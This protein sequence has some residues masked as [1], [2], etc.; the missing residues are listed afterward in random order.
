MSTFD[1][2]QLLNDIKSEITSVV[3]KHLL[4]HFEQMKCNNENIKLIETVLKQMPEF[5]RL[6]RENEDL[7][8]ELLNKKPVET[9]VA[10]VIVN[11]LPVVEPSIKLEL[12]ERNI[13]TESVSESELYKVVSLS[14][15]LVNLQ[16]G[17]AEEDEPVIEEEAEEVASEVAEEEEEAEEAE[18]A[19]EAAEEEASEAAEEEEEEEAEEAE[20]EEEE[21]ASEAAEEEEEE[22]ASEAAEEEASEAAEE[23]EEEEEAEEDGVEGAEPLEEP[24]EEEEVSVVKIKGHGT[25]YTN[26]A[27]NGDIYKMEA[28][29]EVGDQVGKFVNSFPI[30]F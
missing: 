4:P 26:N 21:E 23:E 3:E 27:V 8:R 6:E 25:F 14:E 12:T 16:V 28:D 17:N 29:E 22:E 18:A 24:L 30:F 5:K 11:P 13:Q 9:V 7:K 20:E 10:P 19:S 15:S 2:S 1:L